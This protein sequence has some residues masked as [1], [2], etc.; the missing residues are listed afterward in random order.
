VAGTLINAKTVR[1]EP[2][3]TFTEALA[4]KVLIIAEQVLLQ[5]REKKA[6]APSNVG[7]KVTS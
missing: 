3:L 4:D 7:E 2:P 1:I 6:A 5:L